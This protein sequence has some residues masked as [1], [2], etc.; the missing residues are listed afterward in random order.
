[1]PGSTPSFSKVST[2][3]AKSCDAAKCRRVPPTGYTVKQKLRSCAF[4]AFSI[5]L[6][7]SILLNLTA[8]CKTAKN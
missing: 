3:G 4:N 7:T 1:M 8:R 2:I 6:T 5:R